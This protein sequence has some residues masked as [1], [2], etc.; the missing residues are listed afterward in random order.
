[1]KG[2]IH[3]SILLFIII[4]YLAWKIYEAMYYKSEKFISIKNRIDNHIQ[5][6]NELNEHI[7]ELKDTHVGINQLDYGQSTY[8]D[9]SKWNYKRPELKKRNYAPNIHN[10]SRSVC[11]NASKQPFKYICKYFNIK[12]DEHTL[13]RFEQ[14]LNN[15]EAAEQ[16]K[17]VLKREKEQI[18]DNIKNEIPELIKSFS[19]KNLE[20][21]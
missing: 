4:L 9:N 19:K 2:L 16:G 12:A 13:E 11:D 20:K 5:N 8:N 3:M 14:M 15:F 10:C 21:N 7:E 18:I 17:I 1:M 6:C